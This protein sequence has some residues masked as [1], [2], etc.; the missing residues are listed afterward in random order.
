M[1]T[2]YNAKRFFFF[3]DVE[4]NG[5][6]LFELIKDECKSVMREVKLCVISRILD[7][8]FAYLEIDKKIH[9]TNRYFMSF[10]YQ[11]K[12]HIPIS[13][14]SM[15]TKTSIIEYL[16]NRGDIILEYGIDVNKYLEARKKH[17]KFIL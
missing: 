1:K 11:N 14:K 10:P 7:K 6:E 2:K 12:F 3:Y 9:T 8:T 17:K 15:Q 4:F 13:L 5:D 16:A